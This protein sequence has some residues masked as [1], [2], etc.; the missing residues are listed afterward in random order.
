MA[1][2]ARAAGVNAHVVSTELEGEA[3]FVGRHLAE[4]AASCARDGS[5]AAAPC[6]LVGCGGESTVTLAS[7]GAGGSF[8]AGGPNQEA[9]AAAALHLESGSA[10]LRLLHRHRR[11]GRRH[12]CRRRRRRRAHRSARRGRPGSTSRRAV[13]EHRS[14]EALSGLGDLIVTGPTQTNVND[15]FVIAVGPRAFAMSD[16][17]I[18]LDGVSRRFD[19]LTAVDGVSLEIAAGEFFSL[20][21]PSGCGKTTTLRMIAGFEEPDEGRVLPRRRRRDSALPQAAQ[22]EHGLPGLRAVPAHDGRRQRRLRPP[23]QARRARGDRAEDRRDALDREARRA[24]GPQARGAL[25]RPAPAGRPGARPGQPP[26]R[27]PSRRAARRARPEAQA[28]D[29]ARA[30]ADP[31]IDWHDLRLRH[32][33]PGGSAHDVG[34]HR[35][36]GRR[37]AFS[38]WPIRARSTSSPKTSFVADFI[39]TSNA[40]RVEIGERAG[41]LG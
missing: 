9:A 31:E 34:S 41:D 17:M 38:S 11:L 40:I 30:Q 39:G 36:H 32:A 5:P 22:R 20:L 3:S 29:A 8:G 16:A 35:D 25:G 19:G 15:M 24:R 13:V 23:A 4:L 37:A 18:V 1:A 21:G 2:E 26:R 27:P 10:D 14:G 6:V 7:N 12:R 33:R 28:R